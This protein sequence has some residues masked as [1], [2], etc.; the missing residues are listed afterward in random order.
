M[1][2]LLDKEHKDFKVFWVR[3]LRVP[4]EFRVDWDLKVLMAHFLD[5]VFKV[6]LVPVVEGVEVVEL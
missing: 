5:K 2:Y 1:V 6:L 3:V 4:K